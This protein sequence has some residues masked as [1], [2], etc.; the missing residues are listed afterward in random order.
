MHCTGWTQKPVCMHCTGWKYTLGYGL[1]V[2][3]S[4]K[5]IIA[6]TL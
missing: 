2:L 3:D 4:L 6:I 5:A 1:E